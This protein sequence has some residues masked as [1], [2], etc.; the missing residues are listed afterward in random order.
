MFVAESPA[1]KKLRFEDYL[2]MPETNLRY[3]IIDGE[4][5][6][7]PAPTVE[8][9]WIICNLIDDLRPHVKKR[10]LGV[11]LPAP[12]DVVISRKPLRTR[13]PDILFVSYERSGKTAEELR[14]MKVF[15]IAPDLAIEILSPEET[16]TRLKSKLRDYLRI[17]VR[18]C[19]LVS[20]ESNTVEVMRLTA[21]GTVTT[22]VFSFDETLYSEILPD[23]KL[24][25]A[26]IFATE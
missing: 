3:E 16:R 5:M 20:A 19:W 10:K 11:V 14:A 13:Q 24:K 22:K 6:M 25:V 17:G 8:H 9:Q 7:S 26:D 12:L 15:E 23:L 18:E 1:Q 2:L 4:M 21:I